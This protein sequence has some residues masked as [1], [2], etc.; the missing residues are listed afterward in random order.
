MIDKVMKICYDWCD[1]EEQTS[2]LLPHNRRLRIRT[3]RKRCVTDKLSEY[4]VDSP[5]E[6]LEHLKKSVTLA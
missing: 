6:L 1:Y 3:W 4:N 2:V 5:E